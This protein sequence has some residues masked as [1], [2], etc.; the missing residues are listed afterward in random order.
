MGL[1]TDSSSIDDSFALGA[2]SGSDA[3]G[4]LGEH[5]DTVVLTNNYFDTVGTGVLIGDPDDESTAIST[6]DNPGWFYSSANAPLDTWD[7]SII[8]TES[9]TDL[10]TIP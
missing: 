10:P 8:W 6:I 2:V 7:F 3:Y 1:A 5:D 4:V 9:T